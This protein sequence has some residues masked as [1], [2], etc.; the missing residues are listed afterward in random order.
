MF[1]ADLYRRSGN[2]CCFVCIFSD[3][4]HEWL[5][6][7]FR[8]ALLLCDDYMYVCR[9]LFRVYFPWVT[10][11]VFQNRFTSLWW[12][13]VCLQ[14]LVSCVF[15]MSDSRGVSESL[16]FSVMTACM[17]ADAC[18]VCIFHEWLSGCFR[19]ALLLCDDCMYVCRCLFRVYFPWV[20]LGV[21]Q[22][23]FTSLWWLHVCLQM[24][25]S[26]VF[27]MS[28]SR[29]VSESLYF[30]VMTACMFADACFVCIFHEWLSGCFRIA[31]LLCDDCMYVCR[32]L[33]R[34]Y[35]PW[36]T[37]GVFQNRF[38]SLWWLHVCLQ[39]LVSC[40]FSMSDSR[41]VSESLY[42]SVMTA[43]MF[44]DACF[45]CIFHEWLSGVSE[46]LY[47][48]VMTACVFADACFVCIFHEWLSG[49]FRIALLLCDDCMCV[50]RCLFCVY[51]PWVT[52]WVFQ[53]RFTSLWWLHVCLQMLV[54]CVFSMSDSL[55]VSESLYFSVMTAC[56]FAD[57]CFVC[58]FHE[59]LSGCFRIALLLCD[60]CMCVCRCLFCVYF[61]WVTLW[62]FQNRFTSL[63]WLHVCLQML[64]LCVFSMSD[65]RG[66]SESLYFS[67]MTACMFADACFVC[68]FHEWLSGCFRIALLLCDDCMYVCR[69]LFRVYFPWVTLGVFQNRFT[70]LWWLHVCLQMLV[71]CVFSMSDSRGVSESLYFSVMTACVFADACFVPRSF[72]EQQRGL[73]MD[74]FR[75]TISPGSALTGLTYPWK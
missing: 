31:L 2:N 54:L 5:S 36:V 15:S 62:V 50:C 53:N 46:S 68:I 37:L 73:W 72:Q 41:G 28:D 55:G 29:G 19:I 32:C 12:L 21:F 24:L 9:C 7:C 16:Y 44:A 58:I 75:R 35:F 43:C 30:S 47:F 18:F 65:S 8:I 10:L 49:C 56:V 45:V 63:W 6:G 23:R 51:F 25:V 40:V 33:F 48:S 71:L 39:M 69:C 17:F 14:M 60:D 20:T 64:V 4:F 26:C 13:H 38:T 57:A 66:V 61:P 3:I 1:I 70:S 27:S 22:N 67:V 59:W 52:L 74:V 34:V 42:F 11:G